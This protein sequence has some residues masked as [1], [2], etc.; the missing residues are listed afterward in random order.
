MARVPAGI[1]DR[2]H[3]SKTETQV[4]SLVPSQQSGPT[5]PIH[6]SNF[7][8]N[9]RGRS[10]YGDTFEQEQEVTRLTQKNIVPC[11][12]VHG[13]ADK[14]VTSLQGSHWANSKHFC[15]GSNV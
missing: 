1:F 11:P 13:F 5:S 2:T 3:T 15:K 6:A 9:A 12:G 8:R 10:A 4:N 14:L 7:G